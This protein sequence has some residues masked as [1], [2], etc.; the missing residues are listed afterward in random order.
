MM[1]TAASG[2]KPWKAQEDAR[3]AGTETILVSI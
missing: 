3:V 2:G 1:V